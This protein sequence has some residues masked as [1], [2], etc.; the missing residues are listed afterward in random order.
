LLGRC[1][2]VF[3][4]VG[5]V[6]GAGVSCFALVN[7]EHF[8]FTIWSFGVFNFSCYSFYEFQKNCVKFLMRGKGGICLSFY[9]LWK[10]FVFIFWSF[11]VFNFLLVILVVFNLLFW[12]EGGH[13]VLMNFESFLFY[14]F[15]V[16]K[17][18]IFLL[19]ILW[20]FK[21]FCVKFHKGGEG[22]FA[23]LLVNFE[24]FL[25]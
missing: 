2:S 20:V 25:F 18:S 16:P 24:S 21:N 3:R 6:E 4:W 11:K 7:F 19:V 10:F 9:E 15:K 8:C 5:G 17:F 23:F 1:F 12:F 14:Q 13:L 22:L